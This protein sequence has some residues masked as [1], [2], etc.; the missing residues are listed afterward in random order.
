MAIKK[1]VTVPDPIL[2]KHAKKVTAFD[3]DLQ[4]LVNDM[5]QTLHD[6]SGAGL[7]APQIGVSQRIIVLSINENQCT[8]E[9][10]IINPEV[11]KRKGERVCKE[12]C[13][14]IPGYIGEIKRSAEVKVKGCDVYGKEIKIK[15]QGFLGQALE[16]EIDHLNGV[17]Y[18]DHLESQ[19]KLKRLEPESEEDAEEETSEE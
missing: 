16:H 13:L 15:G 4:R 14:S 1:I 17:L 7:A 3:K 6:A 9:L 10:A 11:V 8:T 19:D 18:V 2:R 5:M 12:G